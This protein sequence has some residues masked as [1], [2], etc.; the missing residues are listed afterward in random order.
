MRP[1]GFTELDG[2]L[3][4]S[5]IHPTNGYGLQYYAD[6]TGQIY[7]TSYLTPTQIG[8]IT[9]ITALDGLLY[10][11]DD[12]VDSIGREIQV[13]DPAQDSFWVAFDIYPGMKMKV[14]QKILSY[15]MV[16][17]IVP[18]RME[19]T[20]QNFGNTILSPPGDTCRRH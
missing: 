9:D 11:S 5:G 17:C 16:N 3:F 7:S 13:Y 19:L 2:K 14:T 12:Y 18:Q 4:F 8:G 20:E 15:L 6:S 1:D 10:F